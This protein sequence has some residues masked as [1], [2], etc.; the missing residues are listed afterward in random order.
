MT[1]L[2]FWRKGRKITDNG[3]SKKKRKK[4]SKRVAYM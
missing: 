3:N 1:S 2:E 4:G